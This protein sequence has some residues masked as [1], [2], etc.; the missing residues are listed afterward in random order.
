MTQTDH[1]SL[2]RLRGQHKLNLRHAHRSEF[3]ETFPYV[4]QYKQGP[5]NVVADPLSSRYALLS[6]L[7]AKLLG[8]ENIKN[9]YA[10]DP[11]FYEE[12]QDCEKYA[13]GKFYRHNRF[14][15]RENRL[16]V[17]NCSLRNLLVQESQ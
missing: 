11:K 15:F 10:E 12:Y 3:I 2:K 13:G 8:L 17:P 9:F 16:C 4:I 5:E 1:E 7:D 6:T 14:L